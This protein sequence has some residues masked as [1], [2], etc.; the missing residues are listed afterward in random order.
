MLQFGNSMSLYAALLAVSIRAQMQYRVSFLLMSFGQSIATGVEAIGL[1]ALFARFGQLSDWTLP[2]VG[3]FYGVVNIGFALADALSKGFDVFGAQ[4]VRTGNFDR[5]LLRPRT[6]VLQLFGHELTLTRV[7]RIAQA[8]IVLGWSWHALQLP[9]GLTQL[10]LLFAALAGCIGL[11][12]GLLILQATLA[13]WTVE[14]LE[15]MNTVTYGGV[16]TAQYPLSIYHRYFRRFFTFV[17]PLGCVAYFPVIALMGARDPLGSSAL[18]QWLAP[19]A[20][21]V[22][23]VVAVLIWRLGVRHYTSTGS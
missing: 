16:E 2:Q 7:G 1:W 22:F 9:V 23:F 21:V 6:A 14:S 5:L 10:L 17:V 3:M 12:V 15:V 11:F 18:L 13:F 20:G 4:Y 8:A 19:L